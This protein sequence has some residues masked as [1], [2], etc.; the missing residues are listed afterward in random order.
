MSIVSFTS[1]RENMYLSA[2]SVG[3]AVPCTDFDATIH[4]VFSSAVNLQQANDGL[5]LTLIT[6]SQADLP[7]G[8]RISTP[9]AFSFD[10]LYV[11]EKVIGRGGR[12]HFEG[13]SLTIELC[14]ARY[15][16]CN[17]PSLMVDMA[18]LIVETGWR[19]AWQVLSKRK[20]GS[21]YEIILE[22]LIFSDEM[23]SLGVYRKIGNV[24]RNLVDATRRCNL[25]DTN[26]IE[27]L[28][29]LGDG[30]TPSCDDFLVGYLAGLWCTVQGRS[31]RIQ[32]I[33]DLGKEICRLSSLTNDISRT[34]LQ[35]AAFGQVSSSLVVLAECICQGEHIDRLIDST[36]AAMQV[37]HTSGM[38][39]VAG[40]L[41]GFAVWDGNHLLMISTK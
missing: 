41:L 39:A 11:G 16:K 7:Q 4:S 37:G 9:K 8:I 28:L 24:V 32:F 27:M 22:N 2:I 21:D 26:I 34:Y 13:S 36:E 10:K 40:L 18:N 35:H 6:A 31:E 20:G 30:L 19:N 17:L 3:Y 14:R 1:I 25:T 15:W 38:A 23:I 12:L 5:L 33:S 29:G